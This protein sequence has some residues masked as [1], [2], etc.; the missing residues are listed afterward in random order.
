METIIITGATSGIGFECALQTARMAP[1][2]QIIIPC[3][4]EKR[5]Q[6][7]IKKIKAKTGHQHLVY[8]PLDLNSLQSVKT[9][10]SLFTDDKYGKVKALINNAG[11]Q[12][13]EETKYT[14]EGFEETFGVNHLAP[15]YLTLLLI[16]HMNNEA[17]I[18]FTASGTHDAKQKTG[19]PAPEYRDP[20]L[21]AFPEKS[22]DTLIAAGQKRYTTS[23][24]CNIL[25]VYEL[26]NRLKNTNISVKAFDPGFVP[27]TGLARTYSP[28]LKF[29]SDY[30]FKILI[31]L[32]PN[33][34]TAST[35]GKRLATLALG[36]AYKNVKGKYF[37]GLKEISSS[38]ESYDT[39]KQAQLWS[40]SV[41]LTGINQT[42]TSVILS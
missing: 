4:N 28:F 32:H 24:L 5:G 35:S 37:E 2:E 38:E 42:D 10:A 15:F 22:T 7:I 9:F 27:G 40:A 19:M 14:A 26:Q 12:N 1:E 39:N 20:K 17:S 3:R 25:T 11:L 18:T 34:N 16:P 30:I 21:M 36:D 6:E 13:V 31:L 8:L 33:V 41:E 23:K 29:I